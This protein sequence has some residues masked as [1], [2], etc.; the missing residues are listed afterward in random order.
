MLIQEY[1][2]YTSVKK[3]KN[4]LLVFDNEDFARRE[5]VCYY[6]DQASFSQ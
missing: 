2:S 3:Q 6:L 5:T 1:S 4:R